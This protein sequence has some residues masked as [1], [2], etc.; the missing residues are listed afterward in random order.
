MFIAD[1]L[2]NIYAIDAVC[3]SRNSGSFNLTFFSFSGVL[4]FIQILSFYNTGRR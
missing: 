4:A 2:R 3:D 1:K